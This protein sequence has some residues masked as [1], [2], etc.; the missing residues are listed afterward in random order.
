MILTG[1]HQAMD[2]VE[3]LPKGMASLIREELD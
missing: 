3:G 2:E 1:A